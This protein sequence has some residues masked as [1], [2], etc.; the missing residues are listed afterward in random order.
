[1]K[2]YIIGIAT[3][4]ALTACN[5]EDIVKGT[6]PQ[7]PT[8]GDVKEINGLCSTMVGDYEMLGEEDMDSGETLKTRASIDADL[9]ATW[10]VGDELSITN[11]TLMYNYNVTE[12]TDG[13]KACSFD[14]ASGSAAHEVTANDNFYAIYP[15]R[16]VTEANGGGKWDAATVTGQIFAQQ[17]YEENMGKVAG[18][19]KFGGYYVSTDAAELEADGGNTNLRF[20]FSP[21]ASIIDVNLA[22][23]D[24]GSD[25]IAGV[26]IRDIS[27]KTIASHFTYNCATK[28]LSTV[29]A[30]EC[31][32]NASSRSDVVEVNFFDSEDQNGHVTYSEIG[33][34][35]I[36]RFY[37][38]PV[39][40]ANGVEI[41]I[42]TQN[43]NYYTKKASAPVGT[44][45]S[46]TEDF[47]INS[48]DVDLAT[49]VKPYYKKYN[50]GTLE[51]ARRGAWM[52]CIPQNLYY[53]MLSIP[54]THDAATSS[55]TSFV[56][57]S[58]T[59]NLTIQQQLESG[60]R[61]VD[62]RPLVTSSDL[63]L[64]H[65]SVTTQETLASAVETIKNYLVQNPT[66]T[67][68]AF[69]HMEAPTSIIGDGYNDN[70][71]K[72]WSNGVYNIVS[73][74]VSD[75]YAL[76]ELKANTPFA[77]CRGKIIFVYR[78]DL[79]SDTK[80]YNA[81]KISWNDNIART[82]YVRDIYNNEMTNFMVSYQDIYNKDNAGTP[83]GY[84]D[85]EYAQK[86][87]VK[88]ES[89]K[90]DI[91][92]RYIDISVNKKDR[93]LVLNFASW[94]GSLTDGNV[95]DHA[96][97]IMKEVNP[98]IVKQHESLGIIFSDFVD[99]TFGNYN[100]TAV[101]LA[102]NF[103]HV[104]MNRSR[105]DVMKTY[106]GGIGINAAGDEFAD[107]TQVYAKPRK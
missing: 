79:T 77:D 23:V 13:G 48:T 31:P 41:T 25:K 37:L 92:K 1:M 26:Y 78:D 100:F 57:S 53:T 55:V 106:N 59:Q 58:K 34:D 86:A 75:G 97:T 76:N 64:S 89:A 36:V 94:A 102:N 40:L 98:Y 72:T 43:G 19:N 61:A 45:Y 105:V 20:K 69:I 33:S 66:E 62:L 103:K 67:V 47:C 30:G 35:K 90:V 11:G 96:S 68:F 82:V 4:L 32:Y 71:R 107:E 74:A 9:N 16:A 91:V 87:G 28:Q 93:R 27:G 80:I 17:S 22:S 49:I 29:D 99:Q 95:F 46:G 15:R 56:N 6:D 65:A 73:K 50:F 54:G 52:G 85:G 39:Q 12:V 8:D 70:Q 42:R 63:V 81:C 51:K 10:A 7:V 18:G 88:N 101:T 83:G 21:L 44:P 14:V 3:L 5:S 104:Y 84:I 24:L 60:V 2:K 38:L